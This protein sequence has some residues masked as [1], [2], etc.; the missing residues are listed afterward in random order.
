MAV[1]CKEEVY[2]IDSDSDYG[3]RTR[4]VLMMESG[5]ILGA[6]YGYGCRR[7]TRSIC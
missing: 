6:N 3:A 7:E 5:L 4:K 2:G 1:M